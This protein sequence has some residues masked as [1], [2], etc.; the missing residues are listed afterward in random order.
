MSYQCANCNRGPL[1]S[2]IWIPEN[3]H[4]IDKNK[5]ICICGKC[6]RECSGIKKLVNEIYWAK[7]WGLIVLDRINGNKI[8]IEYLTRFPVGN[9]YY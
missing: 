1:F 6:Q 3:V 4:F 8:F 7:C 5:K 9:D 2:D